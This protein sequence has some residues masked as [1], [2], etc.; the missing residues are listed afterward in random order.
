MCNEHLPV[1]TVFCKTPY[2][3]HNCLYLRQF[4]YI[5]SF[6]FYQ[7]KAAAYRLCIANNGDVIINVNQPSG[8]IT[9]ACMRMHVHVCELNHHTSHSTAVTSTA[10]VATT[11]IIVLNQHRSVTWWSTSISHNSRD[12]TRFHSYILCA[13]PLY[14]YS[15]INVYCRP[16]ELRSSIFSW[17]RAR[18]QIGDRAGKNHDFFKIVMTFDIFDWNRHFWHFWLFWHF[19]KFEQTSKTF[20]RTISIIKYSNCTTQS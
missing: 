11:D 13:Q 20:S 1:I 16:T 7:Y 8:H 5:Y 17:H 4:H 18:H 10:A 9:Y 2:R 12:L 14:T 15:H 19:S 6:S 3:S